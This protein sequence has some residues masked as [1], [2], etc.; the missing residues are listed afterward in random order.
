MEVNYEHFFRRHWRIRRNLLQQLSRARDSGGPVKISG[1]GEV[2]ACSGGEGFA[3]VC[4]SA[5]TEFAAV[6]LRGFI[7]LP[8]S[9][10]APDLGFSKLSADASGGIKADS[11]G[12]EYLVVE[13]DA[14]AMAAGLFL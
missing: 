10:T 8:Y 9:G 6:Q 3:G 14:S 2:S 12:R 5:G 13:I 1:E 7:K 11:A 4:I